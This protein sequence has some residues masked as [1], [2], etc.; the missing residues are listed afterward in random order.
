MHDGQQLDGREHLAEHDEAGERGGDGAEA[1][2]HGEGR[3]RQ[4]AQ[5]GQLEGVE[6]R[7]RRSMVW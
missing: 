7:R 1:H 5:G 2:Q 4:P 6:Q 3:R